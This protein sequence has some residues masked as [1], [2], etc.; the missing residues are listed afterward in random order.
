MTGSDSTSILVGCCDSVN[1]SG[2]W[3]HKGFSVSEVISWKTSSLK[4]SK[5]TSLVIYIIVTE[6]MTCSL[7]IITDKF[8]LTGSD[9]S[10]SSASLLVSCSDSVNSSGLWRGEGFSV[11]E[12]ISWLLRKTSS[13]EWCEATSLVI[14]IIVTEM[15]TSVWP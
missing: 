5:A 15:M 10:A 9:S 3:R 4:W 12:V 8:L 13:L 11:S 6:M 7:F 14:Y 2:L 1:S